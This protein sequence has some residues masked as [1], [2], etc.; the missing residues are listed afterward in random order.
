M[1]HV[2]HAVKELP[3]DVEDVLGF[4]RD[5]PDDA[6]DVLYNVPNIRNVVLDIKNP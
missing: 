5:V 4:M 2:L 1:E 6:E 3:H